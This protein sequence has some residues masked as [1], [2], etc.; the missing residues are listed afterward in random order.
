VTG[1]ILHIPEACSG[2]KG[3]GDESVPEVMRVESAGLLRHGIA[4]QSS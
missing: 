2:I 4:R 3:Q 1:S